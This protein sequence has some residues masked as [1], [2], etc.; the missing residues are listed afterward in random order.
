MAQSFRQMHYDVFTDERSRAAR[1][2]PRHRAAGLV[3]AWFLPPAAGFS[4]EVPDLPQ[5]TLNVIT[6]IEA[7]RRIGCRRKRLRPRRTRPWGARQ[8]P[9]KGAC[10][11]MC[12]K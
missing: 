12:V 11:T 1:R 6:T 4:A 5:A 7:S 9:Q 3:L 8:Q 2:S 10:A